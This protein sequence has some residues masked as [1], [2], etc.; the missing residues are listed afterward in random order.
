MLYFGD[1]THE[2]KLQCTYYVTMRL[3]RVI[4]AA[5]EKQKYYI[6]SLFL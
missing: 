1:P 2:F 3:V 4:T 5:I 6:F